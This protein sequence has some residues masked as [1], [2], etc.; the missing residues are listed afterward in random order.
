MSAPDRQWVRISKAKAQ[1]ECC[2]CLSPILVGERYQRF[3]GV[4]DGDFE[5]WKTCLPCVR[6]REILLT[7]TDWDPEELVFGT[8]FSAVEE[9]RRNGLRLHPLIQ[10]A[11]MAP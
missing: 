9:A 5:T 6:L 4:W 7:E 11:L 2:E 1:H 8:L 10:L 3:T